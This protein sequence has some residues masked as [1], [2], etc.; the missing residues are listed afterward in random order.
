M[1]TLFYDYKTIVNKKVMMILLCSFLFIQFL[2]IM[3][4]IS[5]DKWFVELL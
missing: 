3:R 4:K 1:Q 2:V 5:S